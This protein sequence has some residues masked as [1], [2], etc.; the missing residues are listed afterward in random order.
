MQLNPYLSFNGNCEAA[1]RFYAE[2]LGGN[3]VELHRYAG[4]PMAEQCPPEWQ[5][6][7]MHAQLALDGQT[8]MASDGMG[9]GAAAPIKGISL[10]LNFDDPADAERVFTA[11]AQGATVEMPLQQTFWARRFGM[12]IDQFG[13]PWMVNC[14]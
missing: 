11:L 5:E 9:P 3:I 13:V 14:E 4:S 6:K 8:L 2:H 7:I 1:F 12:L 10:S